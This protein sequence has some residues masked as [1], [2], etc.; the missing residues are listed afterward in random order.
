MFTWIRNLLKPAGG[1]IGSGHRELCIA[2]QQCQLSIDR[3]ARAMLCLQCGCYWLSN[4]AA[5]KGAHTPDATPATTLSGPAAGDDG[6][7][8]HG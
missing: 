2:C 6:E 8:L 3:G 1:V 7:T 5:G 4:V